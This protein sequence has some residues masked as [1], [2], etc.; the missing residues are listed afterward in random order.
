M[1]FYLIYWLL[2]PILWALLPVAALFNSKI[3]H[4]WLHEKTSWEEA[5]LRRQEIGGSP[6]TL[7]RTRKQAVLFHAASTGEFEQL[8]PILKK[9]DRSRYFV[10]LTFFSP[11]VFIKEKETALAD[12]I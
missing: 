3:R 1:V 2:S 6:S 8:Q 5:S 4:H 11:T 9:V 7:L 12:A 10:L